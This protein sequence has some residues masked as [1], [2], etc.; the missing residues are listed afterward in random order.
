MS[1]VAPITT[2]FQ[3][4]QGDFTVVLYPSP[5]T[6]PTAASTSSSNAAKVTTRTATKSIDANRH[7]VSTSLE[8]IDSSTETSAP[9][10]YTSTSN[11]T[12][13]TMTQRPYT[14]T[15]NGGVYT[16][17]TYV[18]LVVPSGQDQDV[19]TGNKS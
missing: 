11:G 16:S 8:V 5:I 15:S 17:K 4:G 13:V 12:I 19:I 14:Y 9:D 2:V 6:V 1:S 7:Q 3:I 18:Q 10:A